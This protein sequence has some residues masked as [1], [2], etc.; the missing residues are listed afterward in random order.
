MAAA[1]IICLCCKAGIAGGI[2]PRAGKAEH[3]QRDMPSRK[4]R[5]CVA[6]MRSSAYEGAEGDFMPPRIKRL[7]GSFLIVVLVI[8]YAIA[9]M[10]VAEAKLAQSSGFVHFAYFLLSGLLWVLPAMLI[11]KWMYGAPKKR[12]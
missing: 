12:S 4:C 9:A 6:R 11:V 7:V 2:A 1:V 8:V 5:R 3:R 10:V